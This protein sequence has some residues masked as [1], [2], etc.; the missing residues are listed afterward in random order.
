[1][2]RKIPALALLGFFSSRQMVEDDEPVQFIPVSTRNAEDAS[3]T[4]ATL[5]ALTDAVATQWISAWR[6]SGFLDA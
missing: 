4:L 2:V 1:M 3:P 6:A 5:P